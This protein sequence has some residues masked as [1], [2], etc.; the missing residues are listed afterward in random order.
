MGLKNLLQFPKN[1]PYTG[2]TNP[3]RLK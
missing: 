2:L 1:G 3:R